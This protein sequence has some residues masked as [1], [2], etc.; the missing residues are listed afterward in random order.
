VSDEIV[1]HFHAVVRPKPEAIAGLFEDDLRERIARQ[2]APHEAL[3]QN[4]F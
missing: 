3:R 1:C 4:R 2:P